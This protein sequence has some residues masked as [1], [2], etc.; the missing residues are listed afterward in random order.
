MRGDL[1]SPL[2]RA[3]VRAERVKRAHGPA[4]PLWH[5]AIALRRRLCAQM[6]APEQDQALELVGLD[7][8]QYTHFGR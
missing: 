3:L 8:R 1:G 6:S 7:R 2:I 5:R 4:S